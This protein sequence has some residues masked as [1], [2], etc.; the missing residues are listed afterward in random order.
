M[1]YVT[2]EVRSDLDDKINYAGRSITSPGELNYLITNLIQEFI[3]TNGKSYNTIN[4]AVGALECAK[5]ELYR[6]IAAKYEDEKIQQN[7]DVYY[8]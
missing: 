3:N 1:P 7:G 2:K 8:I 4:A 5:I 6:R